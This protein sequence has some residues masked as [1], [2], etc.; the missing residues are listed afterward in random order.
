MRLCPAFLVPQVI[1]LKVKQISSA[2]KYPILLKYHADNCYIFLQRPLFNRCLPKITF[3]KAVIVTAEEE[4]EV[5]QNAT[6]GRLSTGNNVTETLDNLDPTF[7]D[8]EG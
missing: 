5:D 4:N 7:V 3:P 1:C 6:T 2:L 8:Y